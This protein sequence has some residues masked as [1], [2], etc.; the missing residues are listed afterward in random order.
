[1]STAIIP[2]AD[3]ANLQRHGPVTLI[4]VRTPAEFASV[5][6]VGATLMPLASFDPAKAV[7]A[8]VG[9]PGSAIFLICHSGARATEAAERCAAAGFSE[10]VVVTGGTTAWEAAG[11]PVERSAVA[12]FGVER[13][14]RCVIGGGVLVGSILAYTVHP[15]WAAM[16]GFFGAGLFFAGLTD[17][18]ALALLIARMPWNR[19][20]VATGSCCS[21]PA[22]V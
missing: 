20:C 17:T 13:Q 12:S 18:C 19:Q 16:S 10:M 3:V 9:P 15:A 7:A 14:V 4:D 2:A 21:P 6:A 11:L 1:M 8:R 22:K 5:H